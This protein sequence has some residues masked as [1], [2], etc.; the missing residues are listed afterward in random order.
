MNVT[1]YVKLENI[2]S[3]L[4][5]EDRINFVEQ[6]KELVLSNELMNSASFNSLL[7]FFEFIISLLVFVLVNLI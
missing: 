3:K 2:Y 7:L 6:I 1:L 5:T 4:E